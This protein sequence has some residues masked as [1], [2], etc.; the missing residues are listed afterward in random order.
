MPLLEIMSI[1]PA[2][3][4]AGWQAGQAMTDYNLDAN[5]EDGDS[6]GTT[7]RSAIGPLARA[8]RWRLALL[9]QSVID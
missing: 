8:C 3:G 1:T 9:I 2:G 7:T 5:H 4:Q 6:S